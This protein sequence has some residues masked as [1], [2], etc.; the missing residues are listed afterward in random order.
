MGRKKNQVHAQTL[1]ASH[2]IGARA[3]EALPVAAET[4]S[5]SETPEPS[6]EG[7]ACHALNETGSHWVGVIH[8]MFDN[9]TIEVTWLLEEGRAIVPAL[10]LSHLSVC[11]VEVP[12]LDLFTPG[13]VVLSWAPDPSGM[14]AHAKLFTGQI[15]RLFSD[16]V[17]E[18][19]TGGSPIL[20][21][22]PTTQLF[23]QVQVIGK[24]YVGQSVL[25][26]S[27]NH[28]TLVGTVEHLFEG[29]LQGGTAQVRWNSMDGKPR[30]GHLHDWPVA[31]LH[32]EIR[33]DRQTPPSLSYGYAVP[34]APTYPVAVLNQSEALDRAKETSGLRSRLFLPHDPQPL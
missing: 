22:L 27:K 16:G 20:L 11:S 19:Q 30:V 17:A 1:E 23:R 31:S 28:E 6:Q 18:L 7:V 10:T 21:Y 12:A 26:E 13:Q 3:N 34:S 4:Q 5:L 29:G 14:N 2:S 8:R 33:L 25:S 24:I 9:D 32:P 15:T